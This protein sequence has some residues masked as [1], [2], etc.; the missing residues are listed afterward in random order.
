MSV[1]SLPLLLVALVVQSLIGSLVG[2]VILRAACSL[3]NKVFGGPIE[4]QVQ[5]SEFPQTPKPATSVEDD[6]FTGLD[7]PYRSPNTPLSVAPK[8]SGVGVPEPEYGNAFVICFIA[9]VI[10]GVLGLVIGSLAITLT[11]PTLAFLG[12]Q[13]LFLLLAFLVFALLIKRQLPT[14]IPLAMA[15]TGIFLL[16][17]MAIV[18]FV[19]GISFAVMTLFR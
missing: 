11:L 14:S 19:T 6:D 13:F 17:G 18:A 9:S 8:R 4:A 1:S 12:L 3:F 5:H 2:A 15:V 10:N 7:S 16:I